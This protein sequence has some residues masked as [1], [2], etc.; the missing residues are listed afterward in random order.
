MFVWILGAFWMNPQLCMVVFC[1]EDA[2]N[3][4]VFNAVNSKLLALCNDVVGANGTFGL[5]AHWSLKER[6]ILW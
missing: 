3:S 4:F 1:I 2:V 5:R 6:G